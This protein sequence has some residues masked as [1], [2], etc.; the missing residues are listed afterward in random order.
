MSKFKK[1]T[2]KLRAEGYSKESAQRIAA[3]EG[4]KKY[5]KEVMAEKSAESR[6]ENESK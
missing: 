3:A 1:F 5:G 6:K 2:E 4:D